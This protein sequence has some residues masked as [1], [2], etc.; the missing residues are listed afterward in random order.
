MSRSCLKV[1]GRPLLQQYKKTSSSPNFLATSSSA[2][3]QLPASPHFQQSRCGV[4]SRLDPPPS[5]FW[6]IRK[7]ERSV[8]RRWTKD[9]LV[10]RIE[11]LEQQLKAAQ[12]V[13]NGG[14]DGGGATDAT[15]AV[16]AA[17]RPQG[18]DMTS[19]ETA[20]FYGG[21]PE[22]KAPGKDKKGKKTS[23]DPSKYAT[24]YVAFKFAY[25]GK[26]YGGFEY[27]GSAALP[28]IEEELWKAFVTSCLIVPKGNPDEVRWEDPALEYSKCGRTDR[29]VSA[30]GQVIALRVRSNR[31]L[32]KQPQ[33]QQH[34]G[35]EEG[36]PDDAATQEE[37]GT[38]K[39]EWNDFEDEI[40]YCRILNRL[41]PKDIRMLAW[42][43]STPANF[44]ARH[45]CT[46][47]QY[48][49]FFTQP[50]FAP[51]PTSL[52]HPE[53]KEPIKDG[54]LDIDRMR[55][56]A[57]KYQGLH[58]FRNFCKIDGSKQLTNFTRR[59]F[60]SDIVEVKDSATAMPFLTQSDFRPAGAALEP[61]SV[62]PKV[63]YFHVRGS[64]FLWHQIRCMIAVLFTV[65]Q[66]LE[67]PSVIDTLFDVE[68]TPRRPNYVMADEVPLVLWDCVF[69]DS[70][71]WVYLGDESPTDKHSTH[72][73]MQDLWQIWRSRK[74]DELLA[75][76]LHNLVAD[77]GDFSLR[78]DSRAPRHVTLSTRQF[79]G[80]DGARP[81]GKYLPMAKKKMNSSPEEVND[82]TAQK[83]GYANGA[84]Y[85]AALAEKREAAIAKAAAV[86]SELET[87]IDELD[88]AIA[89]A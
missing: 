34:D 38:P 88:K 57:K 77:Q 47:R 65:A 28:T 15:S 55:E 14:K 19:P 8:Y 22:R 2:L 72:G 32:P 84:E 89:T 76:Q 46:E 70:L 51:I 25:L 23:I 53:S 60:E 81:V 83:K 71:E 29:G 42:C 49:Y 4:H 52:N 17:A 9:A 41:L 5:N 43:P 68:K 36:H 61:G 7:M 82:K 11:E 69:P 80:S 78:R 10:G 3:V 44:S 12:Q 54:W 40:R 35:S 63:Y 56:A 13:S 59:M 50:A 58:D 20:A 31:P 37:G 30:F 75:G 21:L 66:G 64:A 79:E 1:L 62:H 85:R 39:K 48:R 18:E 26:E 33:P 86:A 16:T 6:T 45:S 27:Q 87:Q 74:M 73:L 24:R 67:E